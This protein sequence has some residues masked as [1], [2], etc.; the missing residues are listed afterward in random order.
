MQVT[1]D[2]KT[3]PKRWSAQ[4]AVVSVILGLQEA[5]PAWEG[6]VPDDWF[7]YASAGLMTLSIVF[8]G[9]KQANIPEE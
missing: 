5:L 2:Y 9:L 6:I 8:Q 1:K 3:I 7:M 4:A